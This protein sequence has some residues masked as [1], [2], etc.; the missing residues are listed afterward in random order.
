[1]KFKKG[2][3]LLIFIILLITYVSANGCCEEKSPGVYCQDDV[4]EGSCS[5][6]PD[7]WSSIACNETTFCAPGCCVSPDGTCSM[8]TGLTTCEANDGTW[9][10][11]PLCTAS[12][13]QKGCCQYETEF[14]FKTQTGCYDI[15][16]DYEESLIQWH[17]E[18]TDEYECSLYNHLDDYGCCVTENGCSWTSGK[19]CSG[20]LESLS[21]NILTGEGFYQ[22]EYCTNIANSLISEGY[23]IECGCEEIGEK[24]CDENNIDIYKTNTCGDEIFQEACNY[25]DSSCSDL[26]GEAKCKTSDCETTFSFPE[27]S[28]F[29]DFNFYD[30]YYSKT[31]GNWEK[32]EFNLGEKRK[33]GD[34]WCIYE[35][36]TGS[37][38]DRI[39]TQHYRAICM[40]GEEMVVSCAND[41]SKIC[42]TTYDQ[43]SDN[44]IGDCKYNNFLDY[45]SI[46]YH[47]ENGEA[48]ESMEEPILGEFNYKDDFWGRAT[49]PIENSD[50]SLGISTVPVATNETCNLATIICDTA[51][52]DAINSGSDSYGW[53]LYVNSFCLRKEF[54]LTAAEYCSS[55]GDCGWNLNILGE[56]GNQDRFSIDR[57]IEK[58]RDVH[59]ACGKDTC[60][61]AGNTRHENGDIARALQCQEKDNPG[62]TFYDGYHNNILEINDDTIDLYYSKIENLETIDD[63]FLKDHMLPSWLSP[64]N[65]Q[66]YSGYAY[67]SCIIGW[68]KAKDVIYNI[69]ANVKMW[70]STSARMFFNI[71]EYDQTEECKIQAVTQ[72]KQY[73]SCSQDII[74]RCKDWHTG[75]GGDKE[76]CESTDIHY[77][78]FD[79][80]ENG[81]FKDSEYSYYFNQFVWDEEKV[82]YCQE[83][84]KTKDSDD[85]ETELEH[86]KTWCNL[87]QTDFYL[88]DD[89]DSIFDY[90][91]YNN[92]EEEHFESEECVNQYDSIFDTCMEEYD[93]SCG[94]KAEGS[95]QYNLYNKLRSLKPWIISQNALN[96]YDR[97][98][99]D[100]NWEFD[101]GDRWFTLYDG[102][103]SG[104]N[105]KGGSTEWEDCYGDDGDTIKAEITFQCNAWSAPSGSNDCSLC[106][107]N[108][109]EGGTWLSY[110]DGRKIQDASCNEWRCWS[111][112]KNCIFV[113]GNQGSDRPTCIPKECDPNDKPVINMYKQPILDTVSH[114]D[115]LKIS[116]GSNSGYSV[117]EIPPLQLFDF[118][119]ET[120]VYSTCKFIE[121][122]TLN[123]LAAEAEMSS[124][125]YVVNTDDFFNTIGGSSVITSP[126]GGGMHILHNATTSLAN[127]EEKIYWVWC[128]NT[129]GDYRES[130]YRI[131]LSASE[132][133]PTTYE[134]GRLV[135]DPP[136]G[137]YIAATEESVMTYVYTEKPAK[138]KYDTT[139]SDEYSLMENEMDT[140][141]NSDQIIAGSYACHGSIDITEG[142]NTFYFLC[143][144]TYGNEMD[145]S[146]EWIITKSDP[147]LISQ[148]APEGTLYWSDLNLEVRTQSGAESGKSTCYYKQ[149]YQ[150]SYDKMQTASDGDTLWTQ[151]QDL[152]EGDYTYN[153]YCE[154][155]AGNINETTISFTVDVDEYDP[156]ITRLYYLSGTL[157][158]VTDEATTCEYDTTSFTYGTGFSM[159]GVTTTDHNVVVT[160]GIDTY[161][162]ICQDIYGNQNTP[163]IVD[164]DYL[165]Q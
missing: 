145:S 107:Q 140:C 162:V 66:R 165:E 149:D 88:F 101:G 9:D 47:G 136:S 144:D 84:Y 116:D 75:F 94:E 7:G 106:D 95:V 20:E 67:D 21:K 164:L 133:D 14:S 129:C 65:L 141:T 22:G 159:T 59:V 153:I 57:D 46:P 143:E 18:I 13:C 132:E 52:G 30:I 83:I 70:D 19:D 103:Y 71:C 61:T 123:A 110:P 40:D 10:S 33:N 37:F 25:P 147:L 108:L 89:G 125:E 64:S 34:S 36:P 112:G 131:T 113:E 85:P 15:Y 122:E 8:N 120:N 128:A 73:D 102:D 146:S 163:F 138:C 127:G 91:C 31:N 135:F 51:F 39:G 86:I 3:L 98:Y 24:Y 115:N 151:A 134:S 119:I 45:Y 63:R 49:D 2:V 137:T 35:G 158:V 76:N 50:S 23:E 78:V 97:N 161:Y 155:I 1:M 53:E 109:D 80:D 43:E 48:T 150:Y 148:T 17:E 90:C 160:E 118:G 99:A 87:K 100:G 117:S 16:A 77:S 124:T 154:D 82:E 126:E 28:I 93:S 32:V 114:P 156:E 142:T 27:D 56:K 72:T 11:D 44:Y 111:L 41:R 26:S 38:K 104:C 121:E 152:G 54:S 79:L 130:S 55:R 68:Q 69:G 96:S 81:K 60:T 92:E 74:M 62:I 58:I 139:Q 157:Y 5:S 42:E 4:L 105:R 6:A 12:T 29:S